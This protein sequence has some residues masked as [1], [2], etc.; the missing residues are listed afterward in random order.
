M[1]IRALTLTAALLI[2][3]AACTPIN[4][5]GITAS[6]STHDCPT[7]GTTFAHGSCT[8]PNNVKAP[9]FYVKDG[10]ESKVCDYDGLFECPASYERTGS[11]VAQ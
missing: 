3:G 5:L 8:L 4:A 6:S 1:N 7:D 2:A 10:A 9:T 11:Y